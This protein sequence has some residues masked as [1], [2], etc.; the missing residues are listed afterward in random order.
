MQEGEKHNGMNEN[1][2]ADKAHWFA[3]R[4]R[5]DFR[6]EQILGTKCEAVY[7][8]KENVTDAGGKTRVRAVIPRVLFIK[9]TT[10]HALE[11]ERE[12]HNAEENTIPPFWIYRYPSDNEI[13]IISQRSIDL[14][15]LLTTD[16]TSRCRIY[17]VKDFQ[18][19]ERVRIT[20][21]IFKGYEGFVKR[22]EKNKHVIV[23]I[24]GVCMM[25]LPFIHPDLL[26]RI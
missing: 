10:A 11:L 21:G 3:I 5:L 23:S 8:P 2:T 12:G 16:D 14:L 1:D 13:Q 25:I 26:E 22:V 20:G 17:T 7:F 4:T 19:S 9:T 15:K 6:A 24:E 18:P